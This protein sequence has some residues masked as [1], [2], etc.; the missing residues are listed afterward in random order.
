MHTI[1]NVLT[2][3]SLQ[4]S[5]P[6][7]IANIFRNSF[8][9]SSQSIVFDHSLIPLFALSASFLYPTYYPF[10]I[11]ILESILLHQRRNPCSSFHS[12]PILSKLPFSLSLLWMIFLLISTSFNRQ[13]V[14]GCTRQSPSSIFWKTIKVSTFCNQHC[15]TFL[16]CN[17]ILVTQLWFNFSLQTPADW[18]HWCRM[19]MK[20]LATLFVIS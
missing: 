8:L 18:H 3:I 10:L 9:L 6:Q 13:K 2:T 4:C 16:S 1:G 11:I 12:C 17:N 5:L 15:K 14:F 20:K 19:T 7:F